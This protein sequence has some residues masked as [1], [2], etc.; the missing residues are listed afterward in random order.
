MYKRQLQKEQISLNTLEKYL[1]NIFSQESEILKIS[2]SSIRTN[3]R[4]LIRIYDYLKGEY[5]KA[6]N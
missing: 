5:K 2:K 3:L 4:R 1:N 6:S